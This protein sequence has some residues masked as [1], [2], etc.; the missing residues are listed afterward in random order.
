MRPVLFTALI[1]LAHIAYGQARNNHWL[2]TNNHV[3]FS[4]GAPVVTNSIHGGGSYHAALS[5]PAGELLIY[6]IGDGVFN[7]AHEAVANVPPTDHIP[8]LQQG[9]L[10]LPW[11]GLS[12][13]IAYF[14]NEYSSQNGRCG[15]A[16]IDLAANGGQGAFDTGMTW[17]TDSST[18]K[19]TAVAHAN[20]T[21]YWVLLHPWGTDQIAA[22][23]LSS[24]GLDT[25]PVI[26]HTGHVASQWIGGN[27]Q[28]MRDGPLVASYAGDK[29][30]LCGQPSQVEGLDSAVIQILSFDPA[31]GSAAPIALL[32]PPIGNTI[33]GLE[34]SPDGSKL[35]LTADHVNCAPHCYTFF[36]YDVSLAD[37]TSIIASQAVVGVGFSNY[38]FGQLELQM[39]LAPDGKI[40]FENTL[41]SN[42][43]GVISAPNAAGNACGFILEYLQMPNTGGYGLPNT[44]R[45]YQDSELETVL[46][47]VDRADLSVAW[48]IP[49][50]DRI[51]LDMSEEG[52]FTGVMRILDSCGS[53][54]RENLM[55]V[56]HHYVTVD[57][58]DLPEGLLSIQFVADHGWR[59]AWKVVKQ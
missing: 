18:C 58:A 16:R 2:F 45:R 21:D 42:W 5:D 38:T 27:E 49:A 53:L 34:F 3:S 35:Y 48:P 41:A 30:A 6:A 56:G 59:R 31:T 40:Y 24:T 54:L 10:L 4:E 33:D 29:L 51:T 8:A 36:Q 9:L 39:V 12:E 26:S 32:P 43:L 44:C 46:H 22:Y 17:F 55:S 23:R 13:R 50:S 7:N 28:P 47:E 25:L 14:Y 19:M 1:A 20:G 37:E 15:Y 11:P 52:S 57:L